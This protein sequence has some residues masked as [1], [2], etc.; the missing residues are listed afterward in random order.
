MFASFATTKPL[1]NHSCVHFLRSSKRVHRARCSVRVLNPPIVKA[2][3]SIVR[4]KDRTVWPELA[5]PK[6]M[7]PSVTVCQKTRWWSIDAP[8]P[9][10]MQIVSIAMPIINVPRQVKMNNICV[11][12]NYYSIPNRTFVIILSMSFAEVRTGEMSGAQWLHQRLCSTERE[13]D[14]FCWLN[15]GLRLWKVICICR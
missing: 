13:G 2:K 14:L 11:K 7:M 3:P 9:A 5:I 6:P 8:K 15:T 12:I 10:S 4:Q 1:I